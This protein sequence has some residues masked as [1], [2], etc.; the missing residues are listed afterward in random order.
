[1]NEKIV[2]LAD[3][4]YRGIQK[5]HKNTKFPYRHA[6]DARH[7]TDEERKRYN[8]AKNKEAASFRHNPKR[9]KIPFKNTVSSL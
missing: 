9:A 8:N 7:L 6:E 3:S 2:V 5:V 4:G 1:M